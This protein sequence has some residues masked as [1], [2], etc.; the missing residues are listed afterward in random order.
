[1]IR[2]T[3]IYLLL[4]LFVT[5]GLYAQELVTKADLYSSPNYLN[6]T[7]KVIG[8]VDRYIETNDMSDIENYVIQDQFGEELI[9]R[10]TNSQPV[11]NTTYEITGTFEE[12]P[13]ENNTPTFFIREMMREE[14][15][16]DDLHMV[17][18]TST[19]EGAEVMRGGVT[20][21][22]TPF[23]I[24]LSN[25]NYSFQLE[26][27]FYEAVTLGLVV[28]GGSLERSVNMDRSI[29]FYLL[30]A[31][32]IVFILLI[33]GFV[34]TKVS[35]SSSSQKNTPVNEPYFSSPSDN[36][37]TQVDNPTIK[38]NQPKEHTVKI[39]SGKFKVLE[40]LKDISE[41]RLYA[42]P[43]NQKGEYTFGRI[44][45]EG[46]YHFQLKSSAVSRNQAKLIV[47]KDEYVL[48]NYA[49]DESNP[50]KVNGRTMEVNEGH[51]LKSGDIIEMGD[52]KLEFEI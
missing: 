31:G 34:Y 32:G 45:G 20:L 25:G 30:A 21:G 12:G 38:I 39:I 19:P 33:G 24:Q 22:T 18:L 13:T 8:T 6:R 36:S 42:N 10:T 26:K 41:L 27:P 51:T 50:T 28:N 43:Q 37:A 14:P 5:A 35:T 9:V 11:V 7:V 47:I 52:V 2:K 44:P 15:M 4:S 49:G 23:N 17:R 48:V 40:G 16:G 29:L 3:L 1:M 46:H